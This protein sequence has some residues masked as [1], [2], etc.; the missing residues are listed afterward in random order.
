MKSKAQIEDPIKVGFYVERDD[1]MVEVEDWPDTIEVARATMVK[2]AAMYQS[3]RHRMPSP[4]WCAWN[5]KE[6]ASIF[7]LDDKV[8][9]EAFCNHVLKLLV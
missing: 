5:Q 3:G 8:R 1:R 4:V 9:G 2:M 7:F 6:F